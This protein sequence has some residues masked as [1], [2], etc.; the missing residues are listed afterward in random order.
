LLF[1]GL[2]SLGIRSTQSPL[3]GVGV[4]PLPQYLERQPMEAYA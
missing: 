3:L 1:P 2:A 4:R